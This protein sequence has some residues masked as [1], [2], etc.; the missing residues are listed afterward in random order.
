MPR[1]RTNGLLTGG[2]GQFY[3]S[4]KEKQGSNRDWKTWKMKVVIEKSWNINYWQKVIEFCDQSKNLPIL[5]LNF[6]KFVVFFADIKKFSISYI[7]RKMA[8]QNLSREAIVKIQETVM[9]KSR[10]SHGKI[11]HKVCGNPGKEG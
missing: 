11:V 10:K 7:L 1:G 3:I 8:A 2:R 9:E 4:G 6:T 5:L